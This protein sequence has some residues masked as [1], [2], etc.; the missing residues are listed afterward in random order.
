MVDPGS[1]LTSLGIG[2][3]LNLSSLLDKMES[4]E[5]AQLRPMQREQQ[6]YKT[7]IS[8][9]G[10]VQDAVS[11]LQK[12]SEDLSKTALFDSNTAST[13]S[14]NFSA[15]AGD[16][17]AAGTY[18]VQVGQ[19]ATRQT[20]VAGQGQASASD[21]IGTGG[22]LSLTTG[23]GT[24]D[25]SSTS[26]DL[27][28]GKTSLNGIRDAINNA[29][30]GAQASV[31]NDGSGS[32]ANRLVLTSSDTGKNSE[33]SLDVT[34]NSN[35]GDLLNFDSSEG[36]TNTNSGL[37]EAQSAQNAKV[38]VNGI[39]D[40]ESQNN[41]VKD[42]IPGVTL[43][44]SSVT[45]DSDTSSSLGERVTVG[46]DDSGVEK[47]VERFVSSY[48]DFRSVVDKQTAFNNDDSGSRNGVLV[49]DATVQSVSSSLRQSL[50]TP[51]SDNSVSVLS[52]V[53]IDVQKDG[54]LSLDKEKL[55]QTMENDPA[56]VKTFLAGQ[57]NE[58]G[59]GVKGVADFV[60]ETAKQLS[61]SG[62]LLSQTQDNLDNRIDDTQERID[63]R[64]EQIDNKISRQRERFQQLDQTVSSLNSTKQF[65]DNKFGS[66]GG[67]VSGLF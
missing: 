13:D 64:Q 18:R 67:G 52:E 58:D 37:N 59:D 4:S 9:F 43:S 30:T 19:L 62:G 60:T 57:D 25:E 56:A 50:S 49:G 26:V 2:S 1:G 8:A 36:A 31:I 12:A 33:I 46:R 3:N 39:D 27:S 22:Q 55:S 7:E 41:T 42:V 48:N 51:I 47:A 17:A 24:A 6:S 63:S 54:S 14:K 16:D 10:K 38:S 20:L 23:K 53:G 5:Q 34:G 32:N 21:A 44:L 40:L 61:E 66:G 28:Q 29:E 65:L 11:G 15:K 45:Q 35:L